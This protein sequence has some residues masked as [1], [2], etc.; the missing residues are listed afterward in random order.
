LKGGRLDGRR[1][2]EKDPKRFR[3]DARFVEERYLGRSV[4]ERWIRVLCGDVKGRWRE[5]TRR[6][7]DEE[8]ED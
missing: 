6:G 2:K 8:E 3:A 7:C 5:L 1:E 4:L